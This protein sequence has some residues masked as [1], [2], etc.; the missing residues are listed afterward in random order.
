MLNSLQ[1]LLLPLGAIFLDLLLVDPPVRGAP[2]RCVSQFSVCC[3]GQAEYPEDDP[4]YGTFLTESVVD[5]G[6]FDSLDQAIAVIAARTARDDIGSDSEGALSFSP[7]LF[8]ISDDDGRL[9]LAGEVRG[10]TVSWCIPVVS[11]EEAEQV[12]AKIEALQAEASFESGWDNF[13][14]AR[15]LRFEASVLEGRLVDPLWRD[16][17][18]TALPMTARR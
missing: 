3:E 1:K 9:V 11:D 4:I 14:T 13:S 12:S 16:A 10:D 6:T 18:R 2:A 5:L 17:A 7:R 15:R 8:K